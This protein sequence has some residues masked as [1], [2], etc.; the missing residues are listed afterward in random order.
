MKRSLQNW[1]IIFL[2]TAVLWLGLLPY[3][4]AIAKENQDKALHYISRLS[5]GVRPGQIQEVQNSGV[6]S[7]L[8]AQLNPESI[9]ESPILKQRLGQLDSLNKTP[10]DLLKSFQKYD[11][12]RQPNNGRNL[13]ETE[14]KELIKKRAK[15]RSSVRQQA[16]KA[17]LLYGLLSERQLQE[18]MVDFWFNHFNVFLNKK[19]I[20]FWIADYEN[21]IRSHAL[22]NFRD[23][24]GLTAHHPAMLVYL[25][26]DLN[27]APNK[28]RKGPLKGINENYARELMELHTLGVDGGYT[29]QDVIALAK[30]FT[31]WSWSVDR[32]GGLGDENSFRFF[33]QR[34]DYSDKIFLGQTIPG[35][36]IEEGEKALDILASHPE[37]A[38]FISYKLAQYFVADEPP[39][40]LVNR[41]A[42]KFESSD[43][44]IKTVLDTLFHSP[45][46]ND[47]KYYQNKF[48][49][50]Y[51]YLLATLRAS[52]IKNPNIKRLKGML[53]QLSMPIY[54]CAT[55]DGYQ[56]TQEAWLNPEGMLKRVS[57]ANTIANGGLSNKKTVNAKQLRATLG[58]QFSPNTK[59]AIAK[60][61]PRLH[62][63]L[64][65]GSPEMMSR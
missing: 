50:P 21:D 59:N 53:A 16:Q 25:D 65:L 46:F 38:K 4:Q 41:L 15:F 31:G 57:F 8:Q 11:I 42:S 55:P 49:T 6:E 13:L 2:S 30:I 56:N 7:Y 51:Q 37:T 48:T 54:G 45:E 47:P 60:S 20:P 35:T 58:N 63:S 5:F 40:S 29:Q 36:G 19:V 10:I 3:N 32:K 22:G 52:N 26:N 34:H 14:K 62:S 23:L 39:A 1:L 18:V 64:I 24:L 27:V 28:K 9:P 44:N 33:P 61:P 43:G 12:K 17:H